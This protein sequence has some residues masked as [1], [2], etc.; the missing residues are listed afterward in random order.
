MSG[1][2]ISGMQM[3]ILLVCVFHQCSC[4]GQWKKVVG[5]IV[6]GLDEN[7]VL[8]RYQINSNS[9]K[10]SAEINFM[11]TSR[12]MFLS[13]NIDQKNNL[14]EDPKGKFTNIDNSKLK[15]VENQ[16][17]SFTHIFKN[18]LDNKFF[19]KL[20]KVGEKFYKE[21]WSHVAYNTLILSLQFISI[22]EK[23]YIASIFNF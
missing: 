15:E 4:N 5:N 13:Y 3:S 1:F 18:L 14:K 16:L 21:N 12:L 10:K 11:G 6:K 9:H 7:F 19:D 23:I 22:E 8:F 2:K 20:L 17:S